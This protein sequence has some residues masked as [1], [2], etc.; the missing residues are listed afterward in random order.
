M[1]ISDN[2]IYIFVIN[3]YLGK[4]RLYKTGTQFLKS[5]RL[6]TSYNFRTGNN[7]ITQTH[8]REIKCILKNLHL[9]IHI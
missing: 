8:I 1:D 3:K 6:I 7:T 9:R 2:I 5:S 4:S